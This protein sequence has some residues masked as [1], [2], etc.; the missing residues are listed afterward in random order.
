[1][2]GR[3]KESKTN[4]PALGHLK[5]TGVQPPKYIKEIKT[6]GDEEFQPGQEIKVDI[7]EPGEFV[8][9]IGISIG[10]GFQGGMKRWHYSGGPKTHGSMSHR[11]PGSIGASASPSRVFK[12]KHMPGHMGSQVKTIQNIKVVKVDTDNNLI[13]VKGSVAGKPNSYL[14]IK[15]A[16]KKRKTEK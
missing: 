16:L 10:K 3:K 9:I 15:Q 5:K 12:G 2:Y 7:F 13:M 11:R 14:I 6:S 8:D 1:G 4:K